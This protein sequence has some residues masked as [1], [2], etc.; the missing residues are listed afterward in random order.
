MST[1]AA[2]NDYLIYAGLI[3]AYDNAVFTQ[4]TN[5]TAICTPVSLVCQLIVQRSVTVTLVVAYRKRVFVDVVFFFSRCGN[6]EAA[7]ASA[8][9][10]SLYENNT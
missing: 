3:R 10:Q 7:R 4:E 8:A 1:K 5:L 9:N 6:K 2:G